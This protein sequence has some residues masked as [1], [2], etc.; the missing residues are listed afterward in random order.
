MARR[1]FKIDGVFCA[2][3]AF[4]DDPASGRGWN[5]YTF[6][7]HCTPGWSMQSHL[8]SKFNKNQSMKPRLDF[9]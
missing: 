9:I 1:G 2:V 3:E 4:K 7:V 6:L 5:S 8:S